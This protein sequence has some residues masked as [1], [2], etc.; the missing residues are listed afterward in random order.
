MI[1]VFPSL[2]PS[3]NAMHDM[4]KHGTRRSIGLSKE[5]RDWLVAGAWHVQAQRRAQTAEGDLT[6]TVLAKR[7]RSN[8]DLD[9]YAFKA[10]ADSLAKGG[11]IGN[12]KQVRRLVAEWVTTGPA[13]CTVTVEPY[14]A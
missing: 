9:N 8:A 6:L 11:A 12:D 1:I 7:P 5:Y 13:G 14:R 2:P 4:L 3:L 10:I